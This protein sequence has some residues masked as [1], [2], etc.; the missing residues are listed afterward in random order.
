MLEGML[1]S[2]GLS[3]NL[4]CSNNTKSGFPGDSVVKN[5]PAKA[6]DTGSIP[7]LGRSPGGGNGKFHGHRSL[8]GYSPRG[9]RV[10]HE[11]VTA[12]ACMHMILTKFHTLF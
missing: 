2:F 10:R 3:L 1:K 9:C 8:V 6:G 4:K 5:P 12:Y 11:L 7:G